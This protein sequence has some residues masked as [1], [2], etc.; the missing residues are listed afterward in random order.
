LYST[1][2]YLSTQVCCPLL[3]GNATFFSFIIGKAGFLQYISIEA[4]GMH[5]IL[6]AF[7][8]WIQQ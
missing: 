1:I 7:S 3:T 2:F 5:L 4:P 8:G 6:L